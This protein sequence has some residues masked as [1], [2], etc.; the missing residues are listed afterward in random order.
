MTI[1]FYVLLGG[2]LRIG[3]VGVDSRLTVGGLPNGQTVAIQGADFLHYTLIPASPASTSSS[4]THSTASPS[5]PGARAVTRRRRKRNRRS[6][7]RRNRLP[8]WTY[9]FS[10][11]SPFFTR[12]DILCANV[13]V[14]AVRDDKGWIGLIRTISSSDIGRRGV[15]GAVNSRLETGNSKT[16]GSTSRSKTGVT[17][18]TG[19]SGLSLL[20]SI[21]VGG[22]DAMFVLFHGGPF[23]EW[24]RAFFQKWVEVSRQLGA[25]CLVTLNAAADPTVNYDLMVLGF[26]TIVRV[27]RD[28]AGPAFRLD[29]EVSPIVEWVV[30]MSGV[31][32]L[33][34]NNLNRV[35]K[36]DANDCL[37]DGGYR[38]LKEDA[39]WLNVEHLLDSGNSSEPWKGSV[40]DLREDV[41]QQTRPINWPLMGAN[42]V[43]VAHILWWA[44]RKRCLFGKPP[45]V[46]TTGHSSA[47][48]HA[49]GD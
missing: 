17:T 45:T 37:S 27:R 11:E 5:N 10:T 30:N 24:S 34:R 19:T 43:C 14:T 47:R 28:D 39:A 48:E 36:C 3:T 41:L 38:N 23:C 9:S 6:Q 2:I 7:L 35:G 32:P 26:P 20:S 13:P 15:T 25:H 12:R 22:P 40:L 18:G 4:A 42:L 44:V 16:H 29:R 31:A 21:P 8:R 1:I 49:H 46:N 33:R